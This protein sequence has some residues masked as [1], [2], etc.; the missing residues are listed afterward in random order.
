MSV[1]IPGK[2]KT[3]ELTFRV[4]RYVLSK[5]TKT[6]I[7]NTSTFANRKVTVFSPETRNIYFKLRA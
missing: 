4:I 5:K 2:L 1:L 6:D 7:F 3:C